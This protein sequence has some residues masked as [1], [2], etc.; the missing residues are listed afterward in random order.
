MTAPQTTSG[1]SVSG[2]SLVVL[3]VMAASATPQTPPFEWIE[4]PRN[5]VRALLDHAPPSVQLRIGPCRAA[6]TSPGRQARS[7]P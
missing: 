6:P 1:E 7:H 5:G 4:P 2:P 3:A